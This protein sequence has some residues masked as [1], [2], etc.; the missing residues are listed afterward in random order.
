MQHSWKWFIY[1]RCQNVNRNAV[2]VPK[3]VKNVKGGTAAHFCPPANADDDVSSK[4]NMELLN[5]EMLKT[6]PRSDVLKELMRRTFANRWESYVNNTSTL[7][8]HLSQYPLLK[9][10]PYVSYISTACVHVN[11]YA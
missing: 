4:R 3:K 6:K 7:S 11:Y 8:E 10:A 9:K 5:T 2:N 1:Y